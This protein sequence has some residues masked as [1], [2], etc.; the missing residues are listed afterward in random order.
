MPREAPRRARPHSPVPVQRERPTKKRGPLTIDD[1]E[2]LVRWLLDTHRYTPWFDTEAAASYLRREPGTL[3]G[4]RSKGEGPRFYM[5]NNL[6]VRYHLDDLD[7]YVRGG[8]RR[9]RTPKWL[10]ARIV[11]SAGD[12]VPRVD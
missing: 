9:R 1:V 2:A 7:A 4:W 6:F 12:A 8:R 10:R 5:I 11:A 3:R